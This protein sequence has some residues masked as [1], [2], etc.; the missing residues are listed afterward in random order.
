MEKKIFSLGWLGIF[1]FARLAK[2]LCNKGDFYIGSWVLTNQNILF[3]FQKINKYNF[4][5]L[6]VYRINPFRYSICNSWLLLLCIVKFTI[7]C[8]VGPIL[9]L[10]VNT[11]KFLVFNLSFSEQTL[12]QPIFIENDIY[13]VVY[14][15]CY[16]ISTSCIKCFFPFN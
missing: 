16:R 5:P 6:T 3:L 7:K 2:G 10:K 15:I 1:R 13:F 11:N 4:K 12:A 14:F 9:I 8:I